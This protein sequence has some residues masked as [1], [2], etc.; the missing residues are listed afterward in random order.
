VLALFNKAVRKLNSYLKLVVERD[1]EREMLE[2][3]EAKA[4]EAGRSA[5]ADRRAVRA[6][7]SDAMAAT[8]ATL[9][10]DLEDGAEGALA[11]LHRG[12]GRPTQSKGGVRLT[13]L[14][15]EE[16][17]AYTVKGDEGEWQR[18]LAAKERSGGGT[19]ALSGTLSL[20][21]DASQGDATYGQVS[22]AVA[23]AAI[24]AGGGRTEKLL[25]EAAEEAAAA[26]EAKGKKKKR[27]RIL[28]GGFNEEA[29]VKKNKKKG[30]GKGSTPK[31]PTGKYK[32]Q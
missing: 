25:A 24:G 29:K 2:R 10:E 31:K 13:L 4:G 1:A 18:A 19:A 6:L 11:K 17:N 14:E 23:A 15:D 32:N 26:A 20:Q 30:G 7:A 12:G 21:R 22:A 28:G 8:G 9:A 27:P 3:S 16:L 5:V